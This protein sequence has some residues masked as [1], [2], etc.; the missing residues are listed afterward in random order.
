MAS[1]QVEARGLVKR[2]AGRPALDGADLVAE[3]GEVTVV[4]GPSGSG[5]TTLLRIL[6]G[7]L[8]PD[9]G[10]VQGGDPGRIGWVGQKPLVFRATA[11][12]N[13]A[14]GLRAR[15]AAE[16]EVAAAVRPVM[17]H[18]GL[19][20]LRDQAARRLSGGEQQRIAVARALV[21]RPALLLLDEATANLDP[22]N[23]AILEREVRRVAAEGA[24][25]VMTTHDL[26]QAR[27]V[28][29]RVALLLRGRVAEEAPA[30]AFFEAPRTREAQ[31]F[32]RG[33]LVG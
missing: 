10:A 14:F 4:L 20:E 21:L 18:L 29:D 1:L 23:V 16:P 5:K 26:A 30:K 31:A 17:A 3:P 27:R 19:W 32:V 11:F 2:F 33:E 28:A 8:P 9:A 7:L 24:T 13:V 12:E 6:A 22:G 15:E 25:V